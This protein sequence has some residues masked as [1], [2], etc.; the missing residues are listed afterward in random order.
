[1]FYVLTVAPA[2]GPHCY[3]NTFDDGGSLARFD[4]EPMLGHLVVA[5]LW[6]LLRCD[7]LVLCSTAFTV[8]YLRWL[9][10]GWLL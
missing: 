2:L 1:M 3:V 5:T 10:G 9:V 4:L 8:L 6:P 7:D